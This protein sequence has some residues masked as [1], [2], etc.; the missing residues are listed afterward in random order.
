MSQCARQ[1][2]M[3]LGQCQSGPD[4]TGNTEMKTSRLQILG[5]NAKYQDNKLGASPIFLC[6]VKGVCWGSLPLKQT[7]CGPWT[8]VAQ[9]TKH[10]TAMCAPQLQSTHFSSRAFSYRCG[11]AAHVQQLQFRYAQRWKNVE[12]LKLCPH[13][14]LSFKHL[15]LFSCRTEKYN[16]VLFIGTRTRD[17]EVIKH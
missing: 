6:L 3:V 4:S 15:L 7:L 16:G 17:A 10:R 12:T 9:Q 13:L 5:V 1:T 2:V 8:L 11:H 14:T